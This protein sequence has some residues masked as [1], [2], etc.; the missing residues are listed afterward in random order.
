LF[1]TFTR[2]LYFPFLLTLV[3]IVVITVYFNY[4]IV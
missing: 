4:Q 3:I 2:F 1:I